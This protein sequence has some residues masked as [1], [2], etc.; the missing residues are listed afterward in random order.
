MSTPEYASDAATLVGIIRH[1]ELAGYEAQF[2][3]REGGELRCGTC[4]AV[5]PAGDY[6]LDRLR[7]T[8]GASDPADT[9]TVAALRCPACGCKGTVALKYGADATAAEAE[10]LRQL[11]AHHEPGRGL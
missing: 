9:A 6:D 10:V 5:S 11:D 4:R 3:P 1:F 8:E 7:R 2:V